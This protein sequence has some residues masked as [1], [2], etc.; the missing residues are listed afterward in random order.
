MNFDPKDFRRALGKFATGVTIITTRDAEG[1]DIGVTAS[2]FN[3]VSIDPPLVLWS[4]DRSAWSASAYRDAEHFAVNVLNT[5][6][7]D[8]SNRFARKGEDKF[9]QSSFTRGRGEVALIDEAAAQ[10]EC[11]TWAV[12]DGGDHDIIVGEVLDYRYRDDVS[13]LV[14]HNG[15]Y[16]ISEMH[17]AMKTGGQLASL[18]GSVLSEYLLFLLRQATFSYGNR[19]YPKLAAFDVTAE[20]WRVLTLLAD[21]PEMHRQ[22]IGKLV[23]QPPQQLADTL[24]WL[25][26]KNLI[27][28]GEE[29]SVTLTDQGSEKARALLDMAFA[30]EAEVLKGLDEAQI[31]GLQK[32]LKAVIEQMDRA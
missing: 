18:Q 31:E 1:E 4:I 6:Q 16:A 11:R 19:F 25:Q 24:D 3:A 13:S 8:V 14:F 10:F 9:G 23:F 30:H 5:G 17:P 20:E 26:E 29:D 28:L 2:S 22:D 32:G 7:V 27:A 12:Y 15:R 21:T